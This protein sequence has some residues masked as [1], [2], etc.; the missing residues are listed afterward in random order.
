METPNNSD[1]QGVPV[2][3]GDSVSM[4]ELSSVDI[5]S[6]GGCVNHVSRAFPDRS[7]SQ[8]GMPTT[9]LGFWE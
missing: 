3:L 9:L 8:L 5:I 1:S 4:G 2:V 7:H 6:M